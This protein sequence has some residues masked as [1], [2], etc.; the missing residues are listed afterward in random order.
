MPRRDNPQ[1]LTERSHRASVRAVATRDPDLARV[2]ARYGVPPFWSREEGFA[3]LVH[4][5]L[6]QQV[7]LAS[8]QAAFDRL[9]ARIGSVTPRALL[10]VSDAELREDGFSRQKARYTRLLA[11]ATL[12]GDVDLGGLAALPDA[13]AHRALTALTGIGRWTADV[14]LVMALRRPDVWPRGDL[15]LEIAAAEVKGDGRRMEA[16][17][18]EQLAETWRPHRASAARILWHHYLSSRGRSD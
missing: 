15:A 8:A 10:A 16:D 1:R 13:D 14:Y 3:T 5:I 11:E 7:S 17:Q 9:A 4:V 6:E 12:G 2:V 18:L